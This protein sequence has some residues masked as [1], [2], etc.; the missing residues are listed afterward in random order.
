MLHQKKQANAQ[1]GS[2]AAPNNVFGWGTVDVL[3]A[4]E[5]ALSL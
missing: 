4:V 3:K 1:C 2:A 5:T